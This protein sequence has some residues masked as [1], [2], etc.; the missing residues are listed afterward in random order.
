MPIS[1]RKTVAVT[2]ADPG[3]ARDSTEGPAGFHKLLNQH[4]HGFHFAVLR[5]VQRLFEEHQSRWVFEV[6][7]FP[8]SVRGVDTRVDF[9]LRHPDR[10]FYI[11]GEC[12]RANPALAHWCFVRAP[13][14]RR[15]HRQEGIYVDRLSWSDTRGMNS[16]EV[17][18]IA[19]TSDAYHVALEARTGALGDAVGRGRGEIDEAATQVLRGVNGLIEA[20]ARAKMPA[21]DEK[22]LIPVVFTTASLWTTD[23]D[24]AAADLRTGNLREDQVG[25]LP[26]LWVA[27]QFATSESLKHEVARRSRLH[28]DLSKTLAS[29][30]VRTVQFVAP[31]G[32]PGFLRYLSNL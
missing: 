8:V 2:E 19:Y 32:I 23:A 4:G 26:K 25:L 28:P 3:N 9:V 20:F 31:D 12:K 27:Y 18:D 15:D 7:E 1:L 6:A 21:N 17:A 24:L 13:Y 16:V 11:V 22:F 29:E 30:Y 14:T 10:P 5:E